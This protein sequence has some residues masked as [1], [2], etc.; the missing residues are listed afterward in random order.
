MV[1]KSF[2]FIVLTLCLFSYAGAQTLSYVDIVR[3][4]RL[5]EQNV[6]Q[7]QALIKKVSDFPSSQALSFLSQLIALEPHPQLIEEARR[8]S[9]RI[10]RFL[11]QEDESALAVR[12]KDKN[13]TLR[14]TL[15]EEEVM[16]SEWR[17]DVLEFVRWFILDKIL[18]IEID[19]QAQNRLSQTLYSSRGQGRRLPTRVELE[20]Q[21][22][23][24]FQS[25]IRPYDED[26][27]K[28]TELINHLFSEISFSSFEYAYYTEP[29]IKHFLWMEW[30]TTTKEHLTKAYMRQAKTEVLRY[31]VEQRLERMGYGRDDFGPSRVR[32][33]Y[34]EIQWDYEEFV[35]QYSKE[36]LTPE[37]L[38]TFLNAHPALQVLVQPPRVKIQKIKFSFPALKTYQEKDSAHFE[39]AKAVVSSFYQEVVSPEFL[40]VL[41]AE[42]RSIF[43]LKNQP[44]SVEPKED[45]QAYADQIEADIN[46]QK[47]FLAQALGKFPDVTP[48]KVGAALDF[49]FKTMKDI[50]SQEKSEYYAPME[51]FVAAAE[52]AKGQ[53]A[54]SE[55]LDGAQEDLMFRD[56][57]LAFMEFC[58]RIMIEILKD[59]I[60]T[61]LE[62]RKH[63]WEEV[64][65]TSYPAEVSFEEEWIERGQE[66]E[67]PEI[68]FVSFYGKSPKQPGDQEAYYVRQTLNPALYVYQWLEAQKEGLLD[69]DFSKLQD[70]LY[71]EKQ[72]Q[73]R[74]TIQQELLRKYLPYV[75]VHGTFNFPLRLEDLGL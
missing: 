60:F 65:E 19:L 53:Y 47:E 35:K 73:S 7:R 52:E 11:N 45:S 28:R 30:R 37:M 48:E 5:T 70:A 46:R 42:C 29:K 15:F 55:V 74:P 21:I 68:E 61:H 26:K 16:G 13:Y 2:V 69:F 67:V 51:A 40:E 10:R 63:Q 44:L 57:V 39:E 14:K 4:L 23:E 66:Y 6:E 38:E 34:R 32:E 33:K 18:D 17:G 75:E 49:Y 43:E 9:Q 64:K 58:D 22:E 72:S 27:S 31:L 12:Y 8:A 41:K 1:K 54:V 24:K 56:A 36:G 20:R 62:L 59:R 50:L 25:I 71:A 3:K